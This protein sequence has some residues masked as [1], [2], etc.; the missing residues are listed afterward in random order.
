VAALLTLLSLVYLGLL[1]W[2]LLQIVLGIEPVGWQGLV[3][4][5]TLYLFLPAPILFV[6]ALLARARL[7]MIL[8][9]L[10]LAL[11]VVLYGPRFAPGGTPAASAATFRVMTFNAGAGSGTGGDPQRVLA[12]VQQANPD[13]LALQELP[14]GTLQL[15]G[16]TLAAQYPYRAYTS[17]VATFSAYPISDPIE[18]KLPEG[19]YISQ[20]MDLLVE[21]RLIHL[22]NVHL[23]RAGPRILGRRSIA[24]F[25]RDYEPELL[26]SQMTELLDRYVRPTVGTQ[27][28]TGDFNQTEWSHPYERI[29]SV[30]TDSYVESGRGLGHTYPTTIEL[31]RLDLRVP[32]VRID[33]VFH[34]ADL[35]ALRARVGPDGGSDHLP[36]VAELAFR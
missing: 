7:A 36:V 1:G 17:D 26:E 34:S 18:L 25:L 23:R 29:S 4:E 3:R 19:S 33:Y 9:L 27:L 14:P 11:L 13:L 12:A 28:L 6:L 15:L 21:D 5:L 16:S 8:S 24:V 30:L 22:T 31:G 20:A 32:L 2:H 10:P 35:T